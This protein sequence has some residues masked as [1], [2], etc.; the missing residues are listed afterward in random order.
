MGFSSGMLEKMAG[1]EAEPVTE[2][3]MLTLVTGAAVV[4]EADTAPAVLAKASQAAAAADWALTRS[5]TSQALVRQGVMMGR[6]FSW[7]PASHWQAV[8]SS[9]QPALGMFSWRHLSCAL[10]VVGLY[11]WKTVWCSGGGLTAHSG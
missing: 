6:S 11:K 10:L 9:L 7:K 5:V 8:S 3:S 1:T 4:A 2:V